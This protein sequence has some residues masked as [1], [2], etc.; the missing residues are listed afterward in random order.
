MDTYNEMGFAAE[1][2]ICSPASGAET[3]IASDPSVADGVFGY[4]ST[5]GKSCVQDRTLW[6][7]LLPQGAP[8]LLRRSAQLQ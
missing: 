2:K 7:S 6:P 8:I 1:G 3:C 4:D 5:T